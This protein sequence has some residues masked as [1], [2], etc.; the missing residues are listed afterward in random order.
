MLANALKNILA[1]PK[2]LALALSAL[3]RFGELALELHSPSPARTMYSFAVL[4]QNLKD[5]RDLKF[6][7]AA[8]QKM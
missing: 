8:S 6:I 5:N 2:L 4:M 1:M 3:N 7:T